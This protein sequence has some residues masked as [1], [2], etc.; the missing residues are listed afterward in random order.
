[1][2]EVCVCYEAEILHI[3]WLE[4]EYISIFI[5]GMMSVYVNKDKAVMSQLIG[6]MNK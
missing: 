2:G 4:I 6:T 3:T 5:W 1:M